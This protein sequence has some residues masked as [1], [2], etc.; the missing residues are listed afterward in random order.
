MLSLV[1]PMYNEEKIIEDTITAVKKFMDE[2]FGGGYEA[3]FV[4]DGSRDNTL[5]IAQKFACDNV[6]I[7]S[8]DKNKGK[9]HAV[10]TGMLAASGEVIFFTDCDLAYGLD[11]ISDG[12]EVFQKDKE[13]DI[14][15]GSRR[16]HKDGFASY[17]LSRKIM[18]KVFFAVLKIYGGV[19][20]SESQ[21]GIKGFRREASKQIFE[22]CE[23][24]G[25]AFDFELLLIAEKLKLNIAEFPAK[26]IYHRESK[27]NPVRDAIK[28]LR[29][30]SRIKKSVNSKFK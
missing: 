28:M 20:Q 11:V 1:I 12:Y 8:Y 7:I 5:E 23:I 2:N 17:T 16:K 18:S 26:V 13:V 6:K 29:D 15:I 9:G 14:L 4:N 25:W 10:R 27:V 21:S 22:M 24:N 19:K 30:V 3:L